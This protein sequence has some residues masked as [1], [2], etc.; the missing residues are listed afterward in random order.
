MEPNT[1][2]DLPGQPHFRQAVFQLKAIS[3]GPSEVMAM[4]C[5][6]LFPAITEPASLD[7]ELSVN[8][9]TVSATAKIK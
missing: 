1:R 8:R 3:L 4:D 2:M 5:Q 6:S 7:L 9:E